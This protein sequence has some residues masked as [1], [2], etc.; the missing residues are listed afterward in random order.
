MSKIQLVEVG[1]RDGLQNESMCLSVDIRKEL[2]ERLAQAGL[3]TIEA[4]AFVSEKWVPQMAQTDLLF[5]ELSQK[6]LLSERRLPVLVPNM[7]GLEQA[8][9]AGVTEIAIFAAASESFSQKNINVTIEESLARLAEVAQE[10]HRNGLS[11]RGYVST[12]LY[13]PYEGRIAVQKVSQVVSRLLEMGCFEVSLGET[14]GKATAFETRSFLMDLCQDIPVTSLAGH[15]HDTYGQALANIL[16]AYE[17]GIC[18]FDSSIAGLGGCPYAVGAGGNVATED[19]VYLLQSIGECQ[20]I[21]LGQL[22]SISKWISTVLNRPLQS[23]TA[24][25]LNAARL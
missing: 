25:A 21:D 13:C 15:F 6:P 7:K 10:A 3:N 18:V 23:K 14:T 2:I 16:I 8:L 20:E 12:I 4:G 9:E 5:R 1:A 19:V 22:V 24:L 11:V 17:K